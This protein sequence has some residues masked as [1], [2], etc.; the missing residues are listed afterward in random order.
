[1][2]LDDNDIDQVRDRFKLFDES[3]A[4]QLLDFVER[5]ADCETL[6]VNCFAG[7]SRSAAVALFIS[8]WLQVP[9]YRDEMPVDA[10]SWKLYNR[11]VC[12][13]MR[14]VLYGPVE[15]AFEAS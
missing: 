2:H 3:H 9:C 13:T 8:E 7:V 1:M 6:A 5:N 11:H 14:K 15:S 12:S 10:L 4:Q